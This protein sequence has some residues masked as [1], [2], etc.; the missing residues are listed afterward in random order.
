[1][2]RTNP[3]SD[4]SMRDM[5]E[6]KPRRTTSPRL[7]ADFGTQLASY[8]QP[9]TPTRAPAVGSTSRTIAPPPSRPGRPAGAGAADP[10]GAQGVQTPSQRERGN[11]IT[12]AAS[13]LGVP[14][15]WGADDPKK[16]L[17]C[18]SFLSRAW[19]ISRQTTDTLEKVAD[20]ISKDELQA[21]DAMN[22]PT[23][24]DPQGYGHVRMFEKWANP[25]K[26]K[27]WVYEETTATGYVVYR[28]ID[29]D[30]RYQPMR[31]RT[32]KDQPV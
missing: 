21:G 28:Q 11:I 19:G 8:M 24:K 7:V 27:M 31:L 16:G 20:P 1:M 2:I 9:T 32:L 30:A 15:V 18:S 12:R 29:Y 23:W 6:F 22:L 10:S 17:D 5:P 26:T 4:G 13:M 25:E 3:V 14:Y